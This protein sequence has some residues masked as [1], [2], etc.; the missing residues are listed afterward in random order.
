[1]A[2]MSGNV[3]EDPIV[4]RLMCEGFSGRADAVLTS[5][6][7]VGRPGPEAM[8]QSRTLGGALQTKRPSHLHTT[9]T[10]LALRQA[11]HLTP[12][13]CLHVLRIE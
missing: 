5:D 10:S 12:N 8:E 6:A 4:I 3:I 1:M 7:V 9:T 11:P 2:I 13:L